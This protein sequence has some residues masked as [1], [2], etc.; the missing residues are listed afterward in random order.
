MQVNGS[1]GLPNIVNIRIPGTRAE[2]MLMKWDLA[3]LAASAGSACSARSYEPSRVLMALGYSKA[4]ARES[5]RFSF[6][7]PTTKEEV[8]RAIK[9]I[10]N[11]KIKV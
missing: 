11:A 6:G 4:H 1:V 2:E 10:E 3:G 8:D 7:V 5:V 9:I